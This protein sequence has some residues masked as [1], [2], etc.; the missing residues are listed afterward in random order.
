MIVFGG[1]DVRIGLPS[2]G[3]LRYMP[4][5]EVFRI[6]GAG[7]SAYKDKPAEW[8]RLLYNFLLAVGKKIH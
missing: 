5:S 4:N 6:K 1:K 7:H 2:A 3:R 8:L